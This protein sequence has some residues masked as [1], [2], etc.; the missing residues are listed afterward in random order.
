MKRVDKVQ[1][2]FNADNEVLQA[3][4]QDHEFFSSTVTQQLE[5]TSVDMDAKEYLMRTN[6]VKT[7]E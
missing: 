5:V 3:N 6:P 2:E 1:K 4:R 7:I